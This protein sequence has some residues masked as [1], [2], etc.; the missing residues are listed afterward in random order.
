M[1]KKLGAALAVG[2]LALTIHAGVSTSALSAAEPQPPAVPQITVTPATCDNKTNLIQVTGFTPDA[3]KANYRFVVFVEG[4]ALALK[5][6]PTKNRQLLLTGEPQDILKVEPK[7]AF[8]YGKNVTIKSYWFNNDAAV[9][10][11]PNAEWE[12]VRMQNGELQ[13]AKFLGASEMFTLVDPTKLNC[14]APAPGDA[15]TAPADPGQ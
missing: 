15:T 13:K 8:A 11:Y 1:L 3:Y 2:A 12:T 5:Q 9:F 7:A 4:E 6:I 14:P 10:K